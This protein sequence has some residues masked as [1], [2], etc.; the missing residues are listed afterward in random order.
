M[1]LTEG[2]EVD[3]FLLD[4]EEMVFLLVMHSLRSFTIIFIGLNVG[5]LVSVILHTGPG[6]TVLDPVYLV[7]DSR[8]EVV[9]AP[10]YWSQY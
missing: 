3:L 4:D 6:P 1:G 9:V 5:P 2:L 8:G 7:S 10:P